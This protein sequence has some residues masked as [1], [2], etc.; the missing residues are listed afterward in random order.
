M[1]IMTKDEAKEFE[2]EWKEAQKEAKHKEHEH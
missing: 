1:K 2:K